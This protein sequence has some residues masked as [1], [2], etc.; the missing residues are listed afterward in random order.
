MED[1]VGDPAGRGLD[2]PSVEY[3]EFLGRGVELAPAVPLPRRV[4]VHPIDH[5]QAGQY[6]WEDDQGDRARVRERDAPTADRDPTGGDHRADARGL[7][8]R[9]A[10]G[11][12]LSRGDHQRDRQTGPQAEGQAGRG[13]EHDGRRA[14]MPGMPALEPQ[15]ARGHRH[16]DRGAG[17]VEQHLHRRPAEDGVHG[18]D[19]GRGDHNQVLGGQQGQP[20]HDS[21]LTEIMVAG[22]MPV[23]DVQ[24]RYRADREAAD[25]EGHSPPRDG[26]RHGQQMC[27]RDCGDTGRG[28]GD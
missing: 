9:P 20:D 18:R 22:V 3:G 8:K 19:D 5:D 11:H 14:E 21:G 12:A 7:A 2:G 10:Q 13:G 6:R 1:L 4:H 27:Q 17:S 15:D 25:P 16:A 24:Q 26:F 23:A 28:A